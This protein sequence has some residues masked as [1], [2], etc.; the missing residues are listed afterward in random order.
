M[1]VDGEVET[2]IESEDDPFPPLEG[3]CGEGVEYVVEG[4][5]L[6]ARCA[7]SAQITCIKCPNQKG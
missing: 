6:M 1:Q 2:E 3:D 4:E 7:L 5:S